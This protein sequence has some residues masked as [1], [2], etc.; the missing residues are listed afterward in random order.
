MPSATILA[1]F[2]GE[3]VERSHKLLRNKTTSLTIRKRIEI[4]LDL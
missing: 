3:E 1:A 2:T 4:L